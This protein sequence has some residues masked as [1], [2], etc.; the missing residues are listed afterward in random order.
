MFLSRENDV[1]WVFWCPDDVF[2]GGDYDGGMIFVDDVAKSGKI[3]HEHLF[4][5]RGGF[6]CGR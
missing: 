4:Y 5:N 1:T 3:R 6:V 2:L